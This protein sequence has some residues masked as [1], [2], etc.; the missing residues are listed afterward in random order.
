[1]IFLNITSCNLVL[2]SLKKMMN[3]MLNAAENQAHLRLKI[4]MFP[5]PCRKNRVGR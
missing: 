3:G 1:M 4:G 2:Q 5:L